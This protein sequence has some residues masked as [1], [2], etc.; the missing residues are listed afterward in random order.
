MENFFS[1]ISIRKN[2]SVDVNT[3]C[4]YVLKEL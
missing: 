2:A 1:N 3:V 4:E